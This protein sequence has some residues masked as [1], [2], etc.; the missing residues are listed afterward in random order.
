MNNI[1]FSVLIPVYNVEKYLN[2]CIDC[3]LGQTY[4]SFEIVLIND[5]STDNSGN[6]CDQYAGIDSRVRVYHQ[7]N[8]GLLKTRRNALA[9]AV[10]DYWIALDSDDFWDND[11]LESINKTIC[12]YDCDMVIFNLR[13]IWPNEVCTSDSIF[14]DRS[15]FTLKDKDDIFKK[16]IS[17]TSLNNLC[18]KAVKRSIVDETNYE[19][20][21]GIKYAEDLLQTL[22]LICK[23]KKIVYIDKPM[24]NYRMNPN[25]MTNTSSPE[26]RIES[27]VVRE[28]VLDYLKL[29]KLDTIEN[30]KLF[31]Q[32]LNKIILGIISSIMNKKSMTKK[33]RYR[34]LEK[35][36]TSQLFID[37]QDYVDTK[38]FYLHERIR[39]LLYKK[40]FYV[41]L[42][43]Y[44]NIAI[45]PI[46]YI[47][48]GK[49]NAK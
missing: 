11:L 25:S 45:K 47:I 39:L 7:N 40:R 3:V 12:D 1:L 28:A 34:L 15:V 42:S 18:N 26:P 46:R 13:K 8:H 5:G 22:P 24:Y 36:S 21:E 23:A 48:K 35:M 41:L 2:K 32:Y 16:I 20:Y 17:G 14:K 33:E 49:N 4:Q 6:I 9:K 31:Y 38:H 10:G 19:I 27:L 44:E 30:L 43:I 37:S 29:L